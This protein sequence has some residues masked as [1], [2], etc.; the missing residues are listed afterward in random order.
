MRFIV[1]KNILT[2]AGTS[3]RLKYRIKSDRVSGTLLERLN[4]LAISDT[5]YRRCWAKKRKKK[6]KRNG[7]KEKKRKFM[8]KT[9]Q[10]FVFRVRSAINDLRSTVNGQQSR[11]KYEGD[12]QTTEAKKWRRANEKWWR[13]TFPL[14]GG[15][16]TPGP[17]R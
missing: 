13:A 4:L 9:L 2:R 1:T 6:K 3:R 10:N 11:L 16:G 14:W 7:K 15:V 8:D 12:N 5:A 17:F